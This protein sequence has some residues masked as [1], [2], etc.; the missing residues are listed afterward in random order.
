MRAGP[1]R[2]APGLGLNA[3]S[4]SAVTRQLRQGDVLLVPVPSI[5]EGARRVKRRDGRI[6]V[7]AGEA[8]GHAHEIAAVGADLLASSPEELYL[9]I[10][11]EGGVELTHEEHAAILVPP[12]NYRVAR[13]REYVP[14]S[15]RPVVD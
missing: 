1:A 5:P 15:I 2:R 7:A 9:R 4:G 3:V 13:Q 6:I 10:L 8:T 14:R 12:G 11:V